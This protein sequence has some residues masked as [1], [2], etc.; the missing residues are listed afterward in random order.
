[1]ALAPG[2]RA[3][4][5]R[6]KTDV[7]FMK[8]VTLE[9]DWEKEVL[10]AG[11]S[12]LVVVDVYNPNWGPC[13]MC[14]GHFGNLFFDN[15]DEYGMRFVRAEATKIPALIEFRDSAQPNFVFYLNG[16]MVTKIAGADIVKIKET[17]FEKAPKLR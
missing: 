1:M 17:I 16:E 8:F 5:P 10:N 2:S 7:S 9:K 11:D 6:L 13:E 3:D 15:G 4:A 12:V 14:S